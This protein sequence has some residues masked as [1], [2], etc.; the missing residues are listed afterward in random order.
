[1][2][3]TYLDND[4]ILQDIDNV[5]PQLKRCVTDE[6]ADSFKKLGKATALT[7][8]GDVKV[9]VIK[10][11]QQA[12]IQMEIGQTTYTSKGVDIVPKLSQMITTEVCCLQYKMCEGFITEGRYAQIRRR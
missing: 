12:D 7:M 8:V 4:N 1:M 6:L 11:D 10:P 9:V 5:L 2:L 3:H